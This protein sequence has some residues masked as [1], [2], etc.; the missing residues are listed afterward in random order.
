[1]LYFKNLFSYN[2]KSQLSF[3]KKLIFLVKPNKKKSISPILI[4]QKIF[5]LYQTIPLNKKNS[6]RIYSKI[7]IYY[8]N[9]NK[10]NL[11]HIKNILKDFHQINEFFLIFKI[12][13]KNHFCVYK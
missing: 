12:K 11:I 9:N 8:Y 10:I 5:F 6:I 7:N 13:L 4:G 3:L 2:S 1:M